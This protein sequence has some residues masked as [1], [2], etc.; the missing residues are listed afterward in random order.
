MAKESL[1]H[2]SCARLRALCLWSREPGVGCARSRA[3]W[4][5]VV[6]AVEHTRCRPCARSSA[7]GAG[8]ARC[9]AR[10]PSCARL[11]RGD[12]TSCRGQLCRDRKFY[13]PTKILPS[14]AKLCRNIEPYHDLGATCRM[15]IMSRH[16]GPCR[17]IDPKGSIVTQNAL[18][19]Q[20]LLR[21][22]IHCHDTILI[23]VTQHSLSR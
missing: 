1:L 2:L 4:A 10:L 12:R 15:W 19:G 7:L 11:C 9:L 13:V 8:H 17:D 22:Y 3:R 23:I 20:L 14:L 21:C 6:I 5:P 16:R 18:P